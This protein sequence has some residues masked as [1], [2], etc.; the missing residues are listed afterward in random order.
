[1]AKARLYKTM[2]MKKIGRQYWRLWG[3]VGTKRLVDW[4][5]NKAKRDGYG[6]RTEKVAEG[7]KLWYLPHDQE[8]SKRDYDRFKKGM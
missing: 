4:E 6:M 8:M 2:P 7:Y 3:T 5:K 1:M